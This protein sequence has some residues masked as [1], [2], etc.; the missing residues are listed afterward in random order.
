LL[1]KVLQSVLVRRPRFDADDE[2]MLRVAVP[3]SA[4]D[5]DVQLMSEPVLPVLKL[6]RAFWSWLLPIVLVETKDVPLY[7][8]SVPVV[9][10]VAFVPPF[11]IESVPLKLP[12]VKQF[13][14]TEKQ[15]AARLIPFAK[16]DDALPVWL[17]FKTE[18][19]PA[20]VEVEVFDTTRALMVLVPA[21]KVPTMVEDAC[22]TKPLCSVPRPMREDAP[23]TVRVPIVAVLL[24]M[25][26]VVAPPWK[27]ARRVV[28]AP[29][30]MVSPL[31]CVPL[32]MVEEAKAVSP[33][34]N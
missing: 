20:N 12:R 3:P 4:V 32:P 31:P 30:L 8:R 5:P 16:V 27:R 15:P 23:F 26:V 34:L 9:Y 22:D 14:P 28:V 6:M 18:R 29:P 2:G 11:A 13:P 10:E 21:C 7:E 19:P 25:L 1:L 24:L 33:P 17:K